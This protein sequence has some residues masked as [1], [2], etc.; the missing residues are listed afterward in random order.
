MSP[1]EITLIYGWRDGGKSTSIFNILVLKCLFDKHFRWAHCR[2]KYNEIAGSTFQTLKDTIKRLGLEDYFIIKEN[3][4]QIINKLKPDN[5]FFGA[6]ADQPDKIR[7]TP[8]L[9]GVLLEEAHDCKESDFASLL[10]TMRNEKGQTVKPKF[11]AVFNNDKVSDK[12]FISK[13]FFDPE[14]SMY[15]QVE[16]VLTTYEDNPFI[17]VE[18]TSKKLLMTCLND[19]AKFELL[20][21]GAFMPEQNDNPFFY[22]LPDNFVSLDA[23]FNPMLPIYVSMDF[24]YNPSTATVYQH[25]IINNDLQHKGSYS[26][27]IDEFTHKG[28]VE[29]M[30]A[31]IREKYRASTIILTGD[32]SGTKHDAGYA[33]DDT[34]WR[35]IE[36][37]LRV[38]SKMNISNARNSSHHFS[39]NA[40]NT[41][42]SLLENRFKVHPKCVNLIA[43]M[44][45]AKIAVDDN[46]KVVLYKD[47]DK[48]Y[49]M[50]AVDTVRY[51]LETAIYKKYKTI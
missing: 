20:K 44:K 43:D 21:S 26:Y 28:N 39:Y 10:G 34:M 25:I 32:A 45:K 29:D 30:A 37:S 23:V 27:C 3:R 22:T 8:N 1:Y 17:D 9:N 16:R 24:N 33:G 6:S 14:S 46:G 18:A 31:L 50:D 38:T 15:N 51:Y 5:Y 11:I 12:S 40:C 35:K 13:A 2:S 7:S 49:G 19:T 47:R 41:V 4:F 48:G 42:I 36:R